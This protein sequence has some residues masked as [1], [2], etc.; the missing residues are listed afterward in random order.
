MLLND[1]INLVIVVNVYNVF[2]NIDDKIMIIICLLLYI[3]ISIEKYY[4]KLGI[5]IDKLLMNIDIWLSFGWKYLFSSFKFIRRVIVG[6]NF[7]VVNFVEFY[8]DGV[9]YVRCLK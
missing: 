9:F 3:W 5:F 8:N 6:R 7:C 2:F 4:V 1:I